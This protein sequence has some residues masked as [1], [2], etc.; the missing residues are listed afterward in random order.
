[1]GNKRVLIISHNPLSD[2]DNNGKTLSSFMRE[3]PRP[4]IAQIYLSPGDPSFSICENFFQITDISALKG[5]V[6][7][8]KAQGNLVQKANSTKVKLDKER[9]HRNRFYIIVRDIFQTRSSLAYYARSIVWRS[10]RWL[11]SELARWLDDF[12][13]E[14]ILFQ[15][16]NCDF[17]FDIVNFVSRKYNIP[18]VM[19]VTDDYVTKKFTINPW[20]WINL[21]RL[22]QRFVSMVRMA[23]CVIVIGDKMFKEYSRRFGGKYYVAMNSVHI[24]DN[25]NVG[26]SKDSNLKLVY[27]GNIGLNRWRILKEI[28]NS[29]NRFNQSHQQKATLEIYSL[30]KPD[31]NILSSLNNTGASKFMG[32]ATSKEIDRIR[33]SAEILVHVESFDKKNKYITRLSVSTKIPEYMASAKCILAIGPKDVASI[34][35]LLEEKVAHV[36]TSVERGSLD[37][38]VEEILVD[39]R[40]RENIAKNALYVARSNHDINK[41]RKDI[42]KYLN[43]ISNDQ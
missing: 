20:F 14:V 13:P 32:S 29:L 30:D 31:S 3:W 21:R 4:K 18:V 25:K 10:K 37:A 35:Y 27:T 24:D 15:S 16:S 26:A 2:Q 33:D 34:E 6:T 43:G 19:E 11:T 7:G 39:S 23:D 22:T 9:L 40:L 5:F 41:I 42:H 28:G 17:A 8:K 1:M 38:G 12:Q 36:L